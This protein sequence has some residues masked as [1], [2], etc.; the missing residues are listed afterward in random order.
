MSEVLEGDKQVLEGQKQV[1][2]GE[3]Q[4]LEDRN[5]LLQQEKQSLEGEDTDLYKCKAEMTTNPMKDLT[6]KVIMFQDGKFAVIWGQRSHA[7]V[8]QK[9]IHEPDEGTKE[10]SGL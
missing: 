3:K 1:L 9:K 4:V 6:L 2:Q 7:D 8:Y 10:N 5:E